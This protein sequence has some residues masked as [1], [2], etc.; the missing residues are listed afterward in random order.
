MTFQEK[1]AVTITSI[2]V[3]VFGAYFALV[4][5]PVA[6][7][8]QRA[9]AFSGLVI[10]ATVVTALLAGVS[11]V[12]LAIVFRSQASGPRMTAIRKDLA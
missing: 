5:G 8:P 12:L 7:S 6:A 3:V 9:Y 10:A 4:L 11:H 1:S 2:L